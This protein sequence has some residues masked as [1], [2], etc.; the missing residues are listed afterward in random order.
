MVKDFERMYDGSLDRSRKRSES[1][2]YRLESDDEGD[3]GDK[4]DKWE[5][6][7]P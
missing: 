1:S 4:Y 7:S 6:R 2:L 3:L 5:N